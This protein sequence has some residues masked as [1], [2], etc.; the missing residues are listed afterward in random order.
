MKHKEF[1]FDFSMEQILLL[2]DRRVE[3]NK[4]GEKRDSS[5]V[6]KS[7]M[8]PTATPGSMA[9]VFALRKML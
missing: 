1:L 6:P 5:S 9:D 3:R 2:V 4:R 7:R 8:H